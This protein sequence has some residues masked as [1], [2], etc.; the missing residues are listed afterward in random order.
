M[1]KNHSKIVCIKLV[2]LPYLYIY[3][4]D[5]RSHLYQITV[6]S[7]TNI[8]VV[9]VRCI[10]HTVYCWLACK[11]TASPSTAPHIINR[12]HCSVDGFIG[13]NQMKHIR[14][15]YGT[16]DSTK[17]LASGIATVSEPRLTSQAG[18]CA[19]LCARRSVCFCSL[20]SGGSASILA[21]PTQYQ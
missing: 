14:Y 21:A 20:R 9:P 7:V 10:V 4:Y 18:E 12:Q 8:S 2:H 3:I 17:S 1:R 5:A 15:R 6:R 19:K 13:V 16:S 11:H